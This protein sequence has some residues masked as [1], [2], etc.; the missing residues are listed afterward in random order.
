MYRIF[1]DYSESSIKAYFFKVSG[2]YVLRPDHNGIIYFYMPDKNIK[3]SLHEFKKISEAIR[4]FDKQTFNKLTLVLL[5]HLSVSHINPSK[6]AGSSD[7]IYEMICSLLNNLVILQL[8]AKDFIFNLTEEEKKKFNSFIRFRKSLIFG[9]MRSTESFRNFFL[10]Y[11][12][13]FMDEIKKFQDLLM[14]SKSLEELVEEGEYSSLIDLMRFL[15]DKSERAVVIRGIIKKEPKIVKES[16]ES[17]EFEFFLIMMVITNEIKTSESDVENLY[18]W[19]TEFMKTNNRDNA[20]KKTIDL[21]ALKFIHLNEIPFNR[22]HEDYPD[23]FYKSF[24]TIPAAE[25]DIIRSISIKMIKEHINI[26]S[27]ILL[28]NVDGSYGEDEILNSVCFL[29]NRLSEEDLYQ[30]TEKLFHAYENNKD[31]ATLIFIFLE[32]MGRVEPLVKKFLKIKEVSLN[33]LIALNFDDKNFDYKYSKNIFNIFINGIDCVH[34]DDKI[35]RGYILEYIQLNISE[36]AKI[37]HGLLDYVICINNIGVEELSLLARIALIKNDFLFLKR[38]LLHPLAESNSCL[39]KLVENVLGKALRASPINTGLLLAYRYNQLPKNSDLE[40]MLESYSLYCYKMWSALDNH[41]DINVSFS[42]HNSENAMMSDG[43]EKIINASQKLFHGIDP[44]DSYKE[45]MIFIGEELKRIEKNYTA[46]I[47][48]NAR[49]KFVP[50]ERQKGKMVIHKPMT[51]E[52]KYIARLHTALRLLKNDPYPEA[53][54][55]FNPRFKGF[56]IS[57][58]YCYEM[59]KQANTRETLIEELAFIR[60]EHNTDKGEMKYNLPGD[61]ASCPQGAQGRLYQFFVLSHNLLMWENR[62]KFSRE[63]SLEL[64]NP[65]TFHEIIKDYMLKCLRGLSKSFHENNHYDLVWLCFA[66][67]FCIT[68]PPE[69]KLNLT[70][71]KAKLAIEHI[72]ENEI[73]YNQLYIRLA[74]IY[75]IS[76]NETSII[77]VDIFL[78]NLIRKYLIE[79]FELNDVAN[80]SSEHMEIWEGMR[81][82]VIYE[83]YPNLLLHFLL[84]ATSENSEFQ[85]Q[86]LV[87]VAG[88]INDPAVIER[89]REN[90]VVNL[91]VLINFCLN[92][93]THNKLSTLL[94]NIFLLKKEDVLSEDDIRLFVSLFLELALKDKKFDEK[95]SEFI[96]AS[97]KIFHAHIGSLIK[98]ELKNFIPTI[99]YEKFSRVRKVLS[100]LLKE[101]L[102]SVEDL[103]EILEIPMLRCLDECQITQ[104][105]RWEWFAS[106]IMKIIVSN[107]PGKVLREDFN[108][109]F[110]SLSKLDSFN[111]AKKLS[112]QGHPKASFQLAKFYGQKSGLK[113]KSLNI[114]LSNLYFSIALHQAMLIRDDKLISSI[115]KN[116]KIKT[117]TPEEIFYAKILDMLTAKD[118]ESEEKALGDLLLLASSI[119]LG[120]PLYSH[121][122]NSEA[123]SKVTHIIRNC[124][125]SSDRKTIIILLNIFEKLKENQCYVQNSVGDMSDIDPRIVIPELKLSLS[126]ERFQMAVKVFLSDYRDFDEKP[127]CNVESFCGMLEIIFQIEN[128]RLIDFIQRIHFGLMK[129]RDYQGNI[130]AMGKSSQEILVLML[131]DIF[132]KLQHKLRVCVETVKDSSFSLAYA[133]VKSR[134]FFNDKIYISSEDMLHVLKNELEID[135]ATI[136]IHFKNILFLKNHQDSFQGIALALSEIEIENQLKEIILT[137]GLNLSEERKFKKTQFDLN[138][139]TIPIIKDPRERMVNYVFNRKIQFNES[140]FNNPIF[141]NNMIGPLKV[142]VFGMPKTGRSSFLL[143]LG[144]MSNEN[145]GEYQHDNESLVPCRYIS[146]SVGSYRT[147]L[148]LL[149][150][151]S[152]NK[153]NVASAQGFAEHSHLLVLCFNITDR[154]S[155]EELKRRIDEIKPGLKR[156]PQMMIVGTHAD[157]ADKRMVSYSEGVNFARA[158]SSQVQKVPYMEVSSTKDKLIQVAF[159]TVVYCAIEPFV[160]KEK[161]ASFFDDSSSR[162]RISNPHQSNAN[163]NSSISYPPPPQ[164]LGP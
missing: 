90:L 50:E 153:I 111:E 55:S 139:N 148:E 78:K 14:G 31:V 23:F 92:K 118:K 77:K 80:S 85:Y 25:K 8:D 105:L 29:Q 146:F 6:P 38:I 124:K 32:N 26:F 110:S 22:V 59:A 64:F 113:R 135:N 123:K 161:I 162:N 133:L 1:N 12:L 158:Q 3:F 140:L 13:E 58:G 81:N 98:Q 129:K 88:Y 157:L 101:K 122:F 159:N 44:Q 10:S 65:Y 46:L 138:V 62:Q 132:E 86:E 71:H 164:P 126:L 131:N 96:F 15:H 56:K 99:T 83:M 30:M 82:I 37:H 73:D 19:F 115:E 67:Q 94:N 60:R 128:L 54:A 97:N 100:H 69:E 40:F 163:N 145:L 155:F 17:S 108:V 134:Q 116:H 109:K 160:K 79:T 21:I 89:F 130:H 70:R 35:Y 154:K 72:L 27:D 20:F 106:G 103:N 76:V 51:E 61:S 117:K 91:P 151:T 4:S 49:A 42:F 142:Y 95:I 43:G 112:L 147:D 75:E 39:K 104:L 57:V 87:N 119:D 74:K 66:Y 24:M 144:G 120:V 114:E 143:S 53:R 63:K 93:Y 156:I 47:N 5:E 84:P 107:N 11:C 48:K 45:C 150:I 36:D 68:L 149:D 127:L 9:L 152:L 33:L 18:L 41:E 137:Y 16:V 28:K 34:F 2:I 52:E 125:N 121:N 102:L 136:G 141:K 7:I